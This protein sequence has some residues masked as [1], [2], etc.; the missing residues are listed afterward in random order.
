MEFRYSS[1]IWILP[2]VLKQIEN[3]LK[4]T[5][6]IDSFSIISYFTFIDYLS[7]YSI[8]KK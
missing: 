1:V 5:W 2:T 4:E 3:D 7:G 6:H 8:I